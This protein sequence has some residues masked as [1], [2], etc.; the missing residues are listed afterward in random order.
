[1]DENASPG[2]KAWLGTEEEPDEEAPTRR[3]FR[4][5][6]S[7]IRPRGCAECKARERG[8]TRRRLLGGSKRKYG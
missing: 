1:M 7:E 3:R 4:R 6:E 8:R 5:D 2:Q